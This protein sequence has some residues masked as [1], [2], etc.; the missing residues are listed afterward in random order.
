MVA[1][2]TA[3]AVAAGVL[4]LGDITDAATAAGDAMGDVAGDA[5]EAMADAAADVQDLM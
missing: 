3:A 4:D 1:A 5:A 2:G